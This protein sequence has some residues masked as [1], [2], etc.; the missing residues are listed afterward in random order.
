MP[1]SVQTHITGLNE[2]RRE[3]R[4]LSG[5]GEWLKEMRDVNKAAADV[6]VR[7]AKRRAPHKS[8]KL[9][10]AIRSTSAGA[11]ARVVSGK[12]AV[13]Y[14]RVIEFGWPGHNIEPQPH[15]YPAVAAKSGEMIEV[16]M[17]AVEEL[18]SRAFPE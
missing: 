7:E 10:G 12:A 18:L 3:L 6:I 11:R 16:Y 9:A 17:S 1:V 15:L 4:K 5:E 13:Q 2:L 14:A 8:G